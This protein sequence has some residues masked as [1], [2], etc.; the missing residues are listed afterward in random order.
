M[1]AFVLD[2]GMIDPRP[3]ARPQTVEA[4]KGLLRQ[5]LA[6]YEVAAAARTRVP[7]R[8]T[9]RLSGYTNTA[10]WEHGN[11]RLEG[12]EERREERQRPVVIESF[13][14]ECDAERYPGRRPRRPRSV[15]RRCTRTR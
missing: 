8:T 9:R 1:V 2:R 14:G 15:L 4:A 3:E 13:G 5:A 7:S 10:V 11:E 12:E 6:I